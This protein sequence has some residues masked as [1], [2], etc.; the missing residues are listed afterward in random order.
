M[1]IST[2]LNAPWLSTAMAR[3]EADYQRSAGTH[4]TGGLKHRLARSLFLYLL[5]NGLMH[6]S[7][8]IVEASSRSTAVCEAYFARLLV[9]RLWL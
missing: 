7:S 2:S 5:C 1:L 8:I 6:E 3:I 4:P 9:C